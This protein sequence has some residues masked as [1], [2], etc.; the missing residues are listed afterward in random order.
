MNWKTTIEEDLMEYANTT[1][2]LER[3]IRNTISFMIEQGI[4]QEDVKYRY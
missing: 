4:A 2:A 1:T 3:W